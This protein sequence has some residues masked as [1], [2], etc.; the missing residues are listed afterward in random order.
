M[1]EGAQLGLFGGA[2]DRPEGLSYWPDLLDPTEEIA[3][4][5]RIAALPFAPFQF[6]GFEGKRR[7][8]SFGWQYRFDGSG[9]AQTDPMPD[10]LL[11]V[12]DKAASFAGIQAAALDHALLIEYREGAGIGWHRDRP[13]FGEVVGIS[14]ASPAP[15]RFRRR[16]GAKWQRFSLLAEPRSAYHLTGPARAEWEHSLVQVEALRYSITFRTLRSRPPERH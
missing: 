8:V 12:R 13:D 10:W 4:I 16:Q 9:L 2:E 3:L 11:P 1:A 15:L 7:T 6:H 14:L 5:D